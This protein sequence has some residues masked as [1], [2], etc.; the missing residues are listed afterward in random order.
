MKHF[1]EMLGRMIEAAGF[2]REEF[3]ARALV[4]PNVLYRNLRSPKPVSKA[5]T[6][7]K[8]AKALGKTYDQLIAAWKGEA[9]DAATPAKEETVKEKSMDPTIFSFIATMTY[10]ECDVFM[11][12][13]DRRMKQLQPAAGSAQ[14]KKGGDGRVG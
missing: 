5:V 12:A 4:S 14:A 9:A 3:A 13:L 11:G 10:N 1:G 8:I 2:E 7:G 6:L